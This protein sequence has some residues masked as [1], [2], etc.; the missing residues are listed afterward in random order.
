M[1]WYDGN[2]G[3]K[4]DTEVYLTNADLTGGLAVCSTVKSGDEI[5]VTTADHVNVKVKI[6]TDGIGWDFVDPRLIFY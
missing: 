6:D 2:G 3:T 5:A 1:Y 4:R